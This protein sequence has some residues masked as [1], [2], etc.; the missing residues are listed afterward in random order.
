MP[1]DDPKHTSVGVGDVLDGKYRVEGVLGTGGMGVVVAAR[2][3][4]LDERVALKFLLPEAL[5]NEEAVMRFEQEARAAVKITSEHVARVIDVGALESG[6]PYIVMELLEGSDLSAWIREK[7]VLPI[8]QAVEFVLHA[9]EAIA[10]AHALGIVHRDLKPANLF[11]VRRKDGLDSVKVL[12]FGISKVRKSGVDDMSG[13]K[14]S[15]IM[16]SPFY[17]SPEQMRASKDVD[18]QSDIWALGV[19]LY[20]LLA[21]QTP[22]AA[23][24]YAETCVRVMTEPHR[25]LRELR[26]DVPPALADAIDKC[27]VKDRRERHA[28]VAEF[29]MALQDF[30]PRRAKASVERILGVLGRDRASTALPP[31]P[32]SHGPIATMSQFGRTTGAVR[33]MKKRAWGFTAATAAIGTIVLLM[34]AA[35]AFGLGL[36]RSRGFSPPTSTAAMVPWIAS[37]NRMPEAPVAPDPVR[38]DV[39]LTT[40]IA[41]AVAL[42]AA[43]PPSTTPVAVPAPPAPRAAPPVVRAPVQWHAVTAARHAAILRPAPAA[44]VAVVA[45]SAS[46]SDAP[47]PSVVTG[48][49]ASPSTPAVDCETPFY[50]DASGTRIFKKECVH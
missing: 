5:A 12:D 36:A 11:V 25:P 6:A 40:A 46:E 31:H 48:F 44:V 2:H 43:L 15:V 24:T 9:S 22:F 8:E 29:A 10:E 37:L 4:Q 50:F 33:A 3:L 47:K 13:T 45:S 21:G 7:G 34:T 42:P 41:P 16:G 38:D 26:P 1:M 35:L 30:C 14:T 20:E 19:I 32:L 17:M 27:L 18:P 49:P 39:G 28:D 23:E